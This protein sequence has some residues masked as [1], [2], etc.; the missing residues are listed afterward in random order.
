[1]KKVRERFS[2]H[3]LKYPIE[4]S[5][6][7]GSMYVSY[8]LGIAATAYTITLIFGLD[9][10]PTGVL[11]SIITTL[12][13]TIPYIGAVSKLIWSHLFFKHNTEISKKASNDSNA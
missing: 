7:T 3:D 2:N 12:F 4:P 9:S 1:M 11:V 10:G 13:I 8:A 6:Y 5:F